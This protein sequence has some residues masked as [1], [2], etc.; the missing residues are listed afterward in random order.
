MVIFFLY[1]FP[2]QYFLSAYS[3]FVN[4]G[5]IG[6]VRVCGQP[7]ALAELWGR[8]DSANVDSSSGSSGGECRKRC[9]Y[10]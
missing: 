7:F 2:S 5:P 6:M 1:S 8:G 10:Q 9:T 4:V 3:Y